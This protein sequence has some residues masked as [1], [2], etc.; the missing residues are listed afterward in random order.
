MEKEDDD[1]FGAFEDMEDCSIKSSSDDAVDLARG[2]IQS[3]A[4]KATTDPFA[5]MSK[6]DKFKALVGNQRSEGFWT[7]DSRQLITSLLPK[8][9]PQSSLSSEIQL[10]LAALCL[11]EEIFGEK[12]QEW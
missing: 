12:E 10:T 7:N 4:S 5:S 9:L 2:Q 6:T 11:L 1:C 8:A 3:K